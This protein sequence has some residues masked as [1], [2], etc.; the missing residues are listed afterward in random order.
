MI[1][2][3]TT[4]LDV[5]KLQEDYPDFVAVTD[6]DR[7]KL[8][9]DMEVRLR[10]NGEYFRAKVEEIDGETVVGKVLREQ[11]S[12]PQPFEYLDWIRFE[13]KNIID[14]YV[15]NGVYY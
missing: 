7:A 3:V 2:D 4:L 13:R 8:G 15:I 1:I 14:I 10:S 5:V 12:F 6:C 11:F 9:L